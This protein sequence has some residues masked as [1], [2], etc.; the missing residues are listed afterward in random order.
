MP[1]NDIYVT[2]RLKKSTH[3]ALYDVQYALSK[4]E[5]RKLNYSETISQLMQHYLNKQ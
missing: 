3:D 2:I 1:Q 5:G 4:Q